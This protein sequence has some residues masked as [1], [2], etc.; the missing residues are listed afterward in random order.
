M[1]L[2]LQACGAVLIAVILIL[3]L[4]KSSKELGSVL[5]IAVCCMVGGIALSYLQNVLDFLS[6]LEKTAGLSS[7]MLEILLKA[8]GIGLLSE[9]AGLI[10][11]DSGNASLGKS[12]KI[13][14]TAVILWLSIP[15]FTA[16]LDLIQKILGGI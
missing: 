3:A 7:S 14:G 16:L 4:G 13:L 6:T 10:C 8:T 9:L 12:L 2:F 15:L 1:T 5:G 11:A